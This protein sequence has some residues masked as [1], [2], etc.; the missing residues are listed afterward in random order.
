MSAEDA[1]PE[2]LQGGLCVGLRGLCPGACALRVTR[3]LAWGLGSDRFWVRMGKGNSIPKWGWVP[4]GA[5]THL[6]HPLWPI[7]SGPP[8]LGVGDVVT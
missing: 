3:R 8:Q 2:P 1:C 5:E 7:P 6:E 4:Q